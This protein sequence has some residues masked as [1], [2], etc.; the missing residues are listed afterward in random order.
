M[1]ITNYNFTIFAK[2]GVKNL[3]VAKKNEKYEYS[4]KGCKRP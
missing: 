3:K 1:P 2:K 4:N